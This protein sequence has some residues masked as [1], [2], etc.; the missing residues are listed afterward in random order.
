MTTKKAQKKRK[1]D[2]SRTSPCQRMKAH[3]DHGLYHGQIHQH[4][5]LVSTNCLPSLLLVRLFAAILCSACSLTICLKTHFLPSFV[6][7]QE[8]TRE[9]RVESAM[10]T[11]LIKPAFVAHYSSCG[12]YHRCFD[13]CFNEGGLL[14]RTGPTRDACRFVCTAVDEGCT[15]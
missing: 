9:R 8:R 11:A 10:A 2:R 13:E 14:P 4:T 1:H 15:T 6:G 12:V 3:H 7:G 5:T